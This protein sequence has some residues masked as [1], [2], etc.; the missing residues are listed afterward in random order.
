M[1]KQYKKMIKPQYISRKFYGK[2][3]Y[4]VTLKVPGIT[5]FRL[6]IVTDLRSYFLKRQDSIESNQEIIIDLHNY[7]SSIDKNSYGKRIE[8]NLIDLYSNDET[9]CLEII[10][11]FK[12]NLVH[13]FAPDPKIDKDNIDA[14]TII[15]KKYPHNKYQYKA[16]LQPH[17]IQDKES[18]INLIDWMSSQPGIKIS[19]RVKQWFLVTTW[20]WDRR[21]IYVATEAD[22]LMLKLRSS[23][24]VGSVF[25]YEIVDK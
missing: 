19:D 8:R 5:V 25:K 24:A 9:F 20:N 10:E 7:L 6:P 2:W 17:R 11:K 1:Q 14:R 3:L 23:D 16:F 15:A 4:K 22:L 18:K 21:Y 13:Y 12:S